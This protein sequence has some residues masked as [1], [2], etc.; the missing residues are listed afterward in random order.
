[1]ARHRAP[2]VRGASHMPGAVSDAGV[3][4]WVVCRGV[5]TDAFQIL[6]PAP[7][8]GARSRA[9]ELKGGGE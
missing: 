8:A 9:S 5:P 6:V 1:M 7:P 2:S 4:P 3:D